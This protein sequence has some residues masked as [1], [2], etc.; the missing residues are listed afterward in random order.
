M[1]V[2]VTAL[3]ADRNKA[4]VPSGG[5][6]GLPIVDFLFHLPADGFIDHLFVPSRRCDELVPVRNQ[7]RVAGHLGQALRILLCKSAHLPDRRVF[8]QDHLTLPVGK[9]F[10]RIGFSYVQR[11]TDFLWNH[12][13]AQIIY[14]SHNSCCFHRYIPSICRVY[15]RR[16][17]RSTRTFAFYH[18]M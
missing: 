15:L 12:D 16:Y 1:L 5:H 13:P 17:R 10:Q 4:S 14:S 8:F 18:Q 9:N 7:R 6:N 3:I 11:S 2:L